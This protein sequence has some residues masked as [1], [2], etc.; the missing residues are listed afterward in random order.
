MPGTCLTTSACAQLSDQGLHHMPVI[1][2]KRHI[3]GMLS[4]SDLV[5]ALFRITLNSSPHASPYASDA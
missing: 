2:E 1:D 5:A 3:V 4:Q